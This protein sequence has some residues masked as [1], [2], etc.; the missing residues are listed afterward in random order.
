MD[1]RLK[2]I[3]VIIGMISFLFVGCVVSPEY[4]RT[5][6]HSEDVSL[7]DA[8]SVQAEILMGAG[9]LA[10]DSGADQLLEGDFIYS[11]TEYLPDISYRVSDDGVGILKV[12]Q[13]DEPRVRVASNYKNEW[14][15]AFNDQVPLEIEVTLGAGDADLDLSG[16]NLEYF[17]L[18]V[19][20][21]AAYVDLNGEYQHDLEVVIQ[22]GVGELTLILPSDINIEANVTGGLGEINTSGLNRQGDL[23]ISQYSGS[24]PDLTIDINGGIGQV[25]LLVR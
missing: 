15:L 2:V 17:S 3:I 25:N 9:K 23:Y 14:E 4:V 10:I 7:E 12:E 19:G 16:L 22:G 8:E 24:G 6:S 1:K 21:G 18:K 20:A 11:L 13:E 5:R